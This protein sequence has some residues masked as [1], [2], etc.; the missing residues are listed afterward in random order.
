MTPPVWDSSH[1]LQDVKSSI[2]LNFTHMNECATFVYTRVNKTFQYSTPWKQATGDG[3][4]QM[5]LEIQEAN[6]GYLGRWIVPRPLTKLFW[7]YS[8][9]R[10][11]FSCLALPLSSYLQGYFH[12]PLR[13]LWEDF[14]QNKMLYEITVSTCCYWSSKTD[15]VEHRKFIQ[16]AV[17]GHFVKNH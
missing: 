9:Q 6:G 11:L 4:R 7:D 16:W 14:L 2:L 10:P 17:C 3:D 12:Q 15:S 13:G 1:T 8:P 5:Q